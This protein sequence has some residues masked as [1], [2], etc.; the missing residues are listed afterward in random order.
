M[1]TLN[2][3]ASEGMVRAG[4][5]AGTDVTGFGLLGHLHKM[6]LASGV[7]ADVSATDVPLMAGARQLAEGGYI[8]GGTRRNLADVEAAVDFTEDVDA[9]M[10]LMLADA[11][12]SGGLL[13]AVPAERV[14]ALVEDLT[15]SVPAAAVIGHVTEGPAGRI[16][17]R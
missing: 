8:S 2:R 6:L 4:V 13:M 1:S 12:T 16:S 17:V 14:T 3:S 5:A 15:G 9:T 11:Q 10:R 7:S